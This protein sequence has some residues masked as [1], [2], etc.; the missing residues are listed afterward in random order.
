MLADELGLEGS[1]TVTGNSN[2]EFIKIAS[3][4]L[5]LLPFRV[6]PVGLGTGGHALNGRDGRS[7][8]H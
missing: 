4:V 7:Y 3:E 1:Q 5:R 8:R 2:G 6:L